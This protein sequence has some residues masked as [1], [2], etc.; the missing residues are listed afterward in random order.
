VRFFVFLCNRASTDKEG[1]AIYQRF[2]KSRSLNSWF[3]WWKVRNI[4]YLSI[5]SAYGRI[6]RG[7]RLDDVAWWDSPWYD[8]WHASVHKN[9]E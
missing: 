2:Y 3:Y 6:G 5:A 8:G 9:R 7:V 1:Q 4:E